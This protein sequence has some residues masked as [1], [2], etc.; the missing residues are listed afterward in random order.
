MKSAHLTQLGASALALSVATHLH[1]SEFP[2]LPARTIGVQV[3]SRVSPP[4]TPTSRLPAS[5]SCASG[6]ERQP[7]AKA[8]QKQ[9][10][11]AFAAAGPLACRCS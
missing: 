8:Y 3:R 1:A 2:K 11:D 10:S 9:V 6:M 7:R 4:T 5:V